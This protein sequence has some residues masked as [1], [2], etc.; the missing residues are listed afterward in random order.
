[1]KIKIIKHLFSLVVL[2]FGYSVWAQPLKVIDLASDSA[3]TLSIDGA[4]PRPIKVPGGGW[5]SDFQSPQIPTMEGVNDH[6]IYE[7][8]IVVP[9]VIDGQ[10]TKI[11]FGAVN[12]GAEVYIDDKFVA[13][14]AMPLVPF[15]VDI[16]AFVK[17]GNVHQLKIKAYHRRHYHGM[18]GIEKSCSLPVG[19]DFP[20]GSEHWYEWAGN[21]KFAYGITTSIEMA[22]FPPVYIRETFI[23]TLVSKDSLQISVWI[24]NSTD[25]PAIIDLGGSLSSWN[26][27]PC[28]YPKISGTT[29]KIMPHMTEEIKLSSVKWGLGKDS[30]W[31]PN[32]PFNE[33][34]KATLHYL[35]L[36]ISQ[37]G[38]VINSHR[39]RFGFVE[40]GE[41]PYY[42]IVNGVRVNGF[43]DNNS[44]GQIGNFDCWSTTPC[45]LPPTDSTKGA[46]EMWKQFQRIG[47]NSMRL[48]TSVPTAYMLETADEA[49]FLLIPEGGSW[50]NNT[51]V[52][53]RKVFSDQMER[54]IF[55]C[56]NHPSVARYSICNE[57]R[58]PNG[59]NWV[60]RGVIDDVHTVDPTRP[61]VIE[62]HNQGFGRIEGFKGPG[63]A[64]IMEHYSDITP[65]NGDIIRGMG[66][67][68]T[69]I[70][71]VA[72]FAFAIREFRIKDWAYFASWSWLNYWPNFLEGMNYERHPWKA[73]NNPDRKDGVNG[74]N[75]PLIRFVQ[76]SLD[77]YLLI[78]HQLQ[79]KQG[80]KVEG[81]RM[82]IDLLPE[83]EN[84]NGSLPWPGYIPEYSRGELIERKIEVFN[85]GIFGNQMSLSWSAHWD[86]PSGPLANKGMV[87]PFE[88]TPGFHTTQNISFTAP[89]P[90]SDSRKLYLVLKS[91]KEGEEVFV[92]DAIFFMISDT[93][94]NEKQQ[95]SKQ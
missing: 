6:V 69:G 11:M 59:E 16:T 42:Y 45:F 8:E 31:W 19:F 18:N 55:A 15:D 67:C 88:V 89:I 95:K 72:P 34:Y 77:P 17:H 3:W 48:S 82:I 28:N 29:C 4:E 86:S 35:D 51:A 14:V 58:E 57:P 56:R 66:E 90:G 91:I 9:K 85:G 43:S 83:R 84:G 30:Y 21:T 92:E 32:I 41:G 65:I 23:K 36:N 12:Y 47:F 24:C 39:D 71:E 93:T 54:V 81:L 46:P 76:K 74:W 40:H 53:D 2:C 50:G 80:L 61:L 26:N 94:Q 68:F 7:R 73:H 13:Y 27:A 20:K 60:W 70:D 44:Y 78:D 22:V 1:M 64:Y 25:Y 62:A 49:G 63:H 52:F 87:G 33:N 75:S 5:N 10:V 37:K 79:S 38:K